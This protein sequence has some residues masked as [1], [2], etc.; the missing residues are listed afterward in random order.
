MSTSRAQFGDERTP[1]ED[2]GWVRA[3]DEDFAGCFKIQN[4][5]G[6]PQGNQTSFRGKLATRGGIP[7]SD[8]K[9]R[10]FIALVGGGGLLVESTNLPLRSA[11]MSL[12]PVALRPGR[13]RLSTSPIA[14]GSPTLRKTIGTVEV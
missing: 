14:M 8:M 4:D 5:S 1:I 6:F 11:R 2:Y 10:E 3:S 12:D 13:G 9:R 7:V